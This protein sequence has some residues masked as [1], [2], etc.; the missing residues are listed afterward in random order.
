MGVILF[1]GHS[2][3]VD[4]IL[5]LQIYIMLES[6]G[7]PVPRVALLT[8]D[9]LVGGEPVVE[10]RTAVLP[11]VGVVGDQV[12]VDAVLGQDLRRGIVK[13]LQRS[14]AAVHEVIGTGMQLPPCGDAGQAPDIKLVKS[15]HFVGKPLKI[16]RDGFH[17]SI[18]GEKQTVQGIVHDGDCTHFVLLLPAYHHLIASV[19]S[20]RS[21]TKSGEAMSRGRGSVLFTV[22]LTVVGLLVRIMI[23]LPR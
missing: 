5:P 21:A 8:P 23:R 7:F 17:V 11:I 13:R 18:V 1:P 12:G 3:A 19:T 2:L 15:D 20:V 6:L 10:G 14:P 22:R 9:H 4:R 16:R